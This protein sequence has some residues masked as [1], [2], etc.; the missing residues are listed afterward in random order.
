MG[1]MKTIDVNPFKNSKDPNEKKITLSKRF[2]LCMICKGMFS[3]RQNQHGVRFYGKCMGGAEHSYFPFN[4]YRLIEK[5]NSAPLGDAYQGNWYECSDCQ[6]LYFNRGGGLLLPTPTCF[7]SQSSGHT[8]HKRGIFK[9]DKLI[10]FSLPIPYLLIH[11]GEVMSAT[12]FEN[13][14]RWCRN[15]E[16]LFYPK[17]GESSSVCPSGG[18]HDSSES[19]Y[20][21]PQEG[22]FVF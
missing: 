17:G 10:G 1:K 22:S 12:P 8:P 5:A 13:F 4:S 9:G 2:F 18:N 21:S 14:W 15:C 19:G 16:M 20:Y 6:A 3:I 11:I 7:E